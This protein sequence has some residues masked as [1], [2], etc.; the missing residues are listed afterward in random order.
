MANDVHTPPQQSKAPP[1]SSHHK[2][3]AKFED[4]LIA[5][6]LMIVAGVLVA[7]CSWL[8]QWIAF[9]IKACRGSDDVARL[10]AFGMTVFIC[11]VTYNL[12]VHRVKDQTSRRVVQLCILGALCIQLGN[13]VQIN[14]ADVCP[15]DSNT[16]A[17]SASEASESS[18]PISA[19]TNVPTPTASLETL[20][21]EIPHA[22][23]I[24]VPSRCH[25]ASHPVA[26]GRVHIVIEHENASCISWRAGLLLEAVQE[27]PEN[28]HITNWSLIYPGDEIFIPE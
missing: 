20:S 3:L 18:P 17:T 1:S 4:D 10:L 9:Q 27:A 28:Q 12:G 11:F 21:P 7:A 22:T 5:A 15:H 16:T 13:V 14:P 2:G 24:P 26:R 6:V 25:Y 23:V 8:S 19:P